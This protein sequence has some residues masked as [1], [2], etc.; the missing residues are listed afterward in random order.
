MQPTQKEAAVKLV[1]NKENKIQQLRQVPKGEKNK[2]VL[3]LYLNCLVG[4]FSS[5]YLN[6]LHS[7]WVCFRMFST[8]P[9]CVF[10]FSPL[11]WSVISRVSLVTVTLCIFSTRFEWYFH[12][13]HSFRVCLWSLE[14]VSSFFFGVCLRLSPFGSCAYFQLVSSVFLHLSYSFRV[15]FFS[16]SFRGHCRLR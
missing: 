6:F 13:L 11:V 4:L 2:I 1:K 9:V 3:V 10:A 16:R 15:C 7:S 8:R 14:F 12:L 5:I